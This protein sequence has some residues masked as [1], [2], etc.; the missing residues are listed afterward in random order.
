MFPTDLW[1]QAVAKCP[2][3]LQKVQSVDGLSALSTAGKGILHPRGGK[4]EHFPYPWGAEE[5][6]VLCSGVSVQPQQTHCT[7][8]PR[9]THRLNHI[10]AW[11]T[12]AEFPI[13]GHS[14]CTH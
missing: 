5:M 1:A 2:G 3:S 8:F 12:G 9:K 14:Q 7:T 6:D 10:P 11:R 4:G 13:V